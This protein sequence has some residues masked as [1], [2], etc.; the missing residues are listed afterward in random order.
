MLWRGHCTCLNT[1]QKNV[2]RHV[3][4]F[5]DFSFACHVARNKTLN[6]VLA[7][8]RGPSG[9]WNCCQLRD[10]HA[11]FTVPINVRNGRNVR[12]E[13]VRTSARVTTIPSNSI[14]II[15]ISISGRERP[16]FSQKYLNA[17][18]LAWDIS[19]PC[20]VATPLV[21]SPA[22]FQCNRLW[23]IGLLFAR[24]LYGPSGPRTTKY[25]HTHSHSKWYSHSHSHC[26]AH[27][28]ETGAIN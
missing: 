28:Q 18:R 9:V 24:C 6:F 25:W 17:N 1:L 15:Q 23:L 3:L 16:G 22:L 26:R 2:K 10:Y 20:P 14:T 5:C 21:V 8:G 19:L 27:C 11:A 7:G 4:V 12:A 13:S